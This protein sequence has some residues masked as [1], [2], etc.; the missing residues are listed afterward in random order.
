MGKKKMKTFSFE[1]LLILI[2]C[3]NNVFTQCDACKRSW[4]WGDEKIDCKEYWGKEKVACE[5]EN[6]IKKGER[7]SLDMTVGLYKGISSDVTV[8]QVNYLLFPREISRVISALI[9]ATGAVFK[10]LNE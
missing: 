8:N 5:D 4:F 1:Q 6:V 7:Q 9:E 3:L 2:L 10:V